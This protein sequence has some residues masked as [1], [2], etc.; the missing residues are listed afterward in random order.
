MALGERIKT[1]RQSSGMSQEKLAELVGVSRQAV[2]KWESDQSAPSTENLFRLAEIFGTTVDFLLSSENTTAMS[3]AEQIYH[4]YRQEDEKRAA[5]KRARLRRNILTA[6]S[7]V[8]SYLCIYLLGRIIW[9]DLSQ[10]SFVGWLILARPGGEHSYLYAWLLSSNMFWYAMAVSVIPAFFGKYRFSLISLAG[11]AVGLAAGIAFGPYP[12]GAALGHS[13]YGWAIWGA[14]FLASAA[15]G[16]IVQKCT[17][18][19]TA[20]DKPE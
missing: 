7:V 14:V 19:S 6:L 13:H 5:A 3:Q 9:C 8:L 20:P 18:K 11:F 10:S 15:L 17:K 4:L 1:C 2:T 16:A 12:E